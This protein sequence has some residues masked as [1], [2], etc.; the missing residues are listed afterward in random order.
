MKKNLEQFNVIISGVGGQGL[1]TLLQ[2]I[3]EAALSLGYD[4]KTSELHGLSQRGGSVEVH[5]RFGREIFSPLI[6]SGKGNLILALETQEALS[7]LPYS[8][9][10]SIFLINKYITPTLS[11]DVPEKEVIRVLKKITKKVFLIPA[12]EICQKELGSEVVAGIYLLAISSFKRFLPIEPGLILKAIKKTIPEKY[13]ELNK[14]A[15]ELAK[16]YGNF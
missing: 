7:S 6:P 8:S 2:I 14:R 10:N 15:F 1:I 4:L 12:S 5:I 13:F 16:N 3:S 11:K 9:R